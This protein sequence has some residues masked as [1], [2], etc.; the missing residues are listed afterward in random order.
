MVLDDIGLPQVPVFALDQERGYNDALAQ[1]GPSF[2]WHA[3]QG[4]VLCDL[5]TKLLLRTR[6][7]ETKPG[8]TDDV[9]GHC[10]GLVE[11]T[12]ENGGDLKLLSVHL[13]EAFD[14]I[15][16]DRSTPRPLVGIVGEIYVRT[17][18]FANRFIVRRL[19]ALG[20]EVLL[21]PMEEW[22]D[23][24]DHMRRH[25]FRIDRN[26]TGLAMEHVKERVKERD[27]RRLSKA[28]EGAIPHFWLEESTAAVLKRASKYL[29]PAVRGEA[30]LSMGR[31]AEYAQHGVAGVVNVTPF[32]CIPGTIVNGLMRGYVADHDHIP[33]LKMQY[34]GT[35]NAGDELRLEAFMHQCRQAAAGR[36]E[37]AASATHVAAD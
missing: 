19:E 1:L 18:E 5:L 14:R 15:P 21:P 2:R 31:L 13:R 36:R 20:A 16:V 37:R 35:A 9:Y 28:F 27:V 25:D 11:R 17:N 33:H 22:I 10:L 24:I 6:P 7:Y 29:D 12:M 23:Y 26:W 30:I 34:D 4:L 8:E 32:H 3:W